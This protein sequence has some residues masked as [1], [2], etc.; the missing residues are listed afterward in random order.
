MAPVHRRAKKRRQMALRIRRTE[1]QVTFSSVHIFCSA[2]AMGRPRRA[3]VTNCCRMR[4]LTSL[5]AISG[6]LRTATTRR[7]GVRSVIL[8]IPSVQRSSETECAKQPFLIHR[9]LDNR[10]AT[11]QHFHMPDYVNHLLRSFA[12]SSFPLMVYNGIMV[13]RFS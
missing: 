13:I 5:P 2:K 11:C 9:H 6:D 7:D 1:R 4:A 8:Y 3:R 12:V 10:E